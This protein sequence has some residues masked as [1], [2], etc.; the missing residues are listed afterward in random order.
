MK[1]TLSECARRLDESRDFNEVFELVKAAVERELKQHRA[2]LTLILA[3]LPTHIAAYHMLSSNIIVINRDILNMVSSAAESRAE[4]N[5]FLFYILTHEY[6]HSLGYTSEREVRRT[7]Q[8]LCER[9]LGTEHLATQMARG[10]L[11]ELYPQLKL[12][13]RRGFGTE[14][15]V[16]RE[17][18]RSSMPYI[19]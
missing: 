9:I 10:S 17:F 13:Q 3:D 2:G 14:F 16:V 15:E 6:L 7:V 4:V 5:A 19:G 8:T 12:L 11:F 1:L 18:D